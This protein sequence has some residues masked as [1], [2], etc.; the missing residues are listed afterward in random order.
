MFETQESSQS[1]SKT[2]ITLFAVGVVFCPAV[3]LLNRGASYGL[4]T[5]AMVIS[6][7]CLGA[8]WV[9]WKKYADSVAPRRVIVRRSI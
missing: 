1:Q 6:A 4:L 9:S 8:A 7:L 3:L 5:I 2:A